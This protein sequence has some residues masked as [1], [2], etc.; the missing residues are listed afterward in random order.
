MTQ[1]LSLAS[2]FIG[3]Q[4]I[5]CGVVIAFGLVDATSPAE[6]YLSLVTGVLYVL[7]IIYEASKSERLAPKRPVLRSHMPDLSALEK[8]EAGC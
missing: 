1:F 6:G 4:C 2:L 5:R 8:G 7:R 3:M